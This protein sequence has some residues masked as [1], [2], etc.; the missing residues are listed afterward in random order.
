MERRRFVLLVAQT[1]VMGVV[2]PFALRS[3]TASQ[4]PGM[5]EDRIRVYS[6][7]AGGYIEVDRMLLSEDAWRQRLTPEQYRIL[8]EEG[9]ER[10]FTGA[11]LDNK[12][13]GVYR[14]AGCGNDLYLSEHKYDSDSG[15]PSFYQAVAPENVSTRIDRRLFMAR[16]E[17]LCSR[18][19]GHLGHVFADGPPPTGQRHCINSGA[20]TFQPL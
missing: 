11:L 13:Q 14:C 10:A 15:W 7:T 12:E 8:R 6:V 17:L 4:E 16:N 3:A 18:C 2:G 9:T 1:W 19:D 20:L 5:T